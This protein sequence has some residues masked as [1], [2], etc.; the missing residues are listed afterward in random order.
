MIDALRVNLVIF[1][2]ISSKFHIWIAFIKLS[3]KFEYIFSHCRTISKKAVKMA[4]AYQC[5]GQ[6]TLT[7]QSPFNQFSS[8]F[9]IRIASIKLSFNTF[10]YFT[11]AFIKKNMNLNINYI[12]S[13]PPFCNV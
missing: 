8:K 4:A 13:V 2:R 1:N 3:F 10:D 5:P 6:V 11:K 12:V 7:N 9:H